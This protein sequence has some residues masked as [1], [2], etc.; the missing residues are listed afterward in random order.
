M[1]FVSAIENG[2]DKQLKQIPKSDL[3]N[4]AT[5]GGNI[6]DFLDVND[7][8]ARDFQDLD[9]MQQWYNLHIKSLFSGREGFVARISS[10]FLQAKNDGITKLAM[11]FGLGDA[12]F[13]NGVEEYIKEIQL[14]QKAIVPNITFIP[15]LCFARC[16]DID[17]V[18]AMFEEVLDF[19]FFKSIDLVGDDRCSV[20]NYKRIYQ[21]AKDHGYLLK[22]HL[23]EFG[24]AQSIRRGVDELGLDEVQHGISAV[25]SKEVMDWL[26]NNDVQLNICPTS[27]IALNRVES[28]CDHPI[29]RLFHHGIRVTINTDDMLI[30]DQSVTQE[31]VNLY[32]SGCLSATELDDIRVNGLLKSNQ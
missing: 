30:F 10:A 2:D 12:A 5:R 26:R 17:P 7:L 16:M 15:E 28:Y 1:N 23:G 11:S 13:F 25:K 4:H 8:P 6:R 20:A 9:G 21:K 18:E 27:N 19:G 24:D 22:A 31:Y 32:R 3:H 14:I 29:K